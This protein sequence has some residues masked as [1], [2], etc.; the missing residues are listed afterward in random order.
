M[1]RSS[2]LTLLL[3]GI[4]LSVSSPLCACTCGGAMWNPPAWWLAESDYVAMGRVQA[5][6]DD[7]DNYRVLV[8]FEVH[9]VW[10]GPVHPQEV[11]ITDRSSCGVFFEVDEVYLVYLDEA[12]GGG[13]YAHACRRIQMEPWIDNDIAEIGPPPTVPSTESSFGMVKALYESR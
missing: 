1:L 9:A 13:F 10:K 7:L 6:V 5:L 3:L 2:A 11:L 8:T 4:I 12:S